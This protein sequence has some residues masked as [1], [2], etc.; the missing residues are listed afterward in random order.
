MALGATQRGWWGGD[1]G[2]MPRLRKIY[3]KVVLK[4]PGFRFWFVLPRFF[5]GLM[6]T[7][8]SCWLELS[9][10]RSHHFIF[11]TSLV[12]REQELLGALGWCWW[13]KWVHLAG[14]AHDVSCRVTFFWR[15]IFYS[16]GNLAAKP[17]CLLQPVLPA[18]QI[19]RVPDLLCKWPWHLLGQQEVRISNISQKSSTHCTINASGHVGS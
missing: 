7:H 2:Y 17:T 13:A 10:S 1:R 3:I 8:D 14:F 9:V 12:Q 4:M 19:L 15:G 16:W 11:T 18:S 5:S 6:S